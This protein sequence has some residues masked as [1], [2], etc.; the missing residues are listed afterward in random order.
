MFTSVPTNYL[1]S[2][3]NSTRTN[4]TTI[5]IKLDESAN[6]SK[7]TEEQIVVKKQQRPKTTSTLGTKNFHG[8]RKLVDNFT[9]EETKELFLMLVKNN[10]TNKQMNL[11]S[12]NYKVLL[13][14][15]HVNPEICQ[16]L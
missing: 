4:E 8:R 7:N 13:A 3:N 16:I 15:Q 12:Q 6:E 11:N 9:D 5:S 1:E 2:L 14:N 10:N